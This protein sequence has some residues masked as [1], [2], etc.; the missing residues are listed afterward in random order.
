MKP[1]IPLLLFLPCGE[2]AMTVQAQETERPNIILFMVDDMGWQDTSVPFW[3]QKTHFNELY[4]TP[5][6]ERL[7]NKGMKFTQAYANSI[8]SPSRV[9]L[10][11]GMNS[12]RHR[13][14]NWTLERGQSTDNKNDVIQFPEWNVN[15][16]CQQAGI[17]RSTYAT[18]LAQLLKDSGYY[19]IHCGKAH[20][21]AR[22]TPGDNPLNMGFKVNIAGFAGGAPGTY[23]AVDNFG[24]HL[25]GTPSSPFAVPGLEKYY[26]KDEFL[27]EV[28]TREALKALDKA[29]QTQQPFYLYMAH[30]A[31]HVPLDKDMRFYPKYKAKGL[32]DNDAAY[33]ALIEGMDKSLGDIMDYLEQKGLADNTIILFMSDNGGLAA[34]SYWRTPL[35]TQNAPLN[36][37]KGS[38][39]EGGIRE[40]MIAYWPKV[41]PAG[42]TCDQY[43]IIE[44]FYP[45]ILEMA[46]VKKYKTVQHIDGKSFVSL[47]KQTGNPFK[48]RSL[49][50]NFPNGWG[51]KSGPGMGASSTIRKGDWKL[52]YYYET[53]KKE[54]FNIKEDISE[55]HNRVNEEPGRVRKMSEE[56]GRY[57]RKVKAQRP[58]FKQSG[59]YTPWPDEISINSNL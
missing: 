20:F 6:M 57:L 7:A 56:L 21:A 38:A 52:I 27:T 31:I 43:L 11:T 3:K 24:N 53:G 2:Y 23:L 46:G 4:E 5:N 40:P 59:S 18:S 26:G 12:A 28:L 39:C 14:T 48:S 13:V 47:L 49:Y 36:N 30:Y 32:S 44:D 22:T 55:K 1:I 33:A 29:R 54:L 45:T 10:Y 15:G 37:G 16:F 17:E 41:T 8:S 35:Y 9:S 34:E 58:T 19:T 50:W 25:D 51:N 42:S